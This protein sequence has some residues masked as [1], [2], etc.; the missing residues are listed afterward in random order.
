MKPENA[1]KNMY[2]DAIRQ[3]VKEGGDT[4][5]NGAIAGGIIGALIGYNNIPQDL[6][7]KVL[8]FDFISWQIIGI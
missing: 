8:T 2:Y 7:N 6:C 5:T 1:E 3:I 4:D